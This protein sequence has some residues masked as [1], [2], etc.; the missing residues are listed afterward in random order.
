[1]QIKELPAG[2]QK[3]V[4]GPAVNIPADLGPACTL[5]PRIPE[6]A[7]II[8]LKFKRKLQFKSAYISDS[9][10]KEKV[11][12]ALKYLQANNDLYKDKVTINDSWLD[13]WQREDP[14]FYS[15]LFT[16]SDAM[17]TDDNEELE[18][19]LFEPQF[20]NIEDVARRN[21]LK[22]VD[23]PG[24]GSCM[25]HAVNDQ[26]KLHGFP[27]QT[28]EELRQE[29]CDYLELNAE[30]F[31]S[32]VTQ[33]IP[34][35][36][37][38][39]P[40]TV[41]DMNIAQIED[42]ATRQLLTWERF[43]E[44]QRTT[45]YGNHITL[46]AIADK[47]HATVEVLQCRQG[48]PHGYTI[49]INPADGQPVQVLKLAFRPQQHYMSLHPLPFHDQVA[50]PDATTQAHP[51]TEEATNDD[52]QQEKEDAEA[53]E[54]S[55][56][57]RGIPHNT[58]LQNEFRDDSV[59]E[60]VTYSIAPGEGQKPLPLLTDHHCEELAYPDKFPSGKGGFHCD[61][62]MKI[63]HRKYVNA[64]LLSCDGRFARDINYIL[65]Q[66]YATEHQQVLSAI[67]IALRN[68]RPNMVPGGR[69]TAGLLRDQT[70]L[71]SIIRNDMAFRFLKNVRGSPPYWQTMFYEAL[72]MIRTLG[73]PTFFLTLSAADLRWPEVIQAVAS[74]YGYD[75][76][77]EEVKEMGWKT[78]CNW[79]NQNPI[80]VARMF[81]HR[82]EAFL[83]KFLKSEA[84]PI[85]VITDYII[86]TEFQARGSPH[87]HCMFWIKDA[88]KMGRSTDEEVIQFIDKHISCSIPED[89]DNLAKFVQDLQV[90][91]HS[92]S[93]RRH[94][95][96]RFNYPKPPVN[97]TIISKEPD[98]DAEET[99]KKAKE[100][101]AAVRDV[102][103]ET[104]KSSSKPTLEEVLHKAKV[105]MEQYENALEVS[106]S[107]RN[108]IL[109]R[110]MNEQCVNA[111]SPCILKAWQAN[112]DFQFIIDAYACLMYVA[113]YVL[114]AEK[115]MS[116][117]LKQAAKEAEGETFRIKT[118]K[119]ASVF[120]THREVSAQEAVYRSLS[121]PL[122]MCSKK[123]IFVNTDVPEKRIGL[124][125]PESKLQDKDEDDDDI[126][127][128]NMIDRYVARP[129][130]L[131]HLCLAD[132]MSIYTYPQRGEAN[133]CA[134]DEFQDGDEEA[135]DNTDDTHSANTFD[136]TSLPKV[137]SLKEG[138]GRLQRRRCPAILRWPAF[139]LHKDPEKYYRSRLMLFVSWRD[140]GKLHGDFDTYQERYQAE[141]TSI[142]DIEAR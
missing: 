32:F 115:G 71:S 20:H 7:H 84:A 22:I 129:D 69:V 91:C 64:R 142:K 94:G 60:N 50:D 133:D 17:Q 101:V 27:E 12:N 125:L 3:G 72:A 85:G 110:D 114:K 93:C 52:E 123:V 73:I 66:Q 55:C 14:E 48:Y 136:I 97:R 100:V 86:R 53:F 119:I 31:Q 76:T 112:M 75:Y 10:N 25:F 8:T 103:D 108:V 49:T 9:V 77:P 74:Q 16:D 132:F 44:Q 33:N 138:L 51:A 80:T 37:D 35:T 109:K 118:R 106:K 39:E 41:E 47:F 40:P 57:L 43:I 116:E 134:N 24:D 126:R 15:A 65:A 111:Y 34:N 6:S 5:L 98:T 61:R 139:S 36:Q 89:D 99:I 67:N 58:L 68:I 124:I 128:K 26:L 62:P 96:C 87:I 105:T 88:P 19:E 1:M 54:K 28:G 90:H 92:S 113:S 141:E 42:D 78:K 122:R 4:R 81:Q 120:L 23:V 102:L 38:T 18:V 30:H 121:M 95:H 63:T 104:A 83:N 59:H 137:I 107:G 127:C 79:I 2:R 13:D 82:V 130:I 131:E 135:G 21:K 117:I 140:E 11:I 45:G 56:R 46:Q 29:V 70:F